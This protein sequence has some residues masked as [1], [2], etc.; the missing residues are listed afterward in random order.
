MKKVIVA[1]KNPVKIESARQAF[2]R[3][4][5]EQ[6]F[7]FEGVD[8]P[9]GVPDQPMGEE[10]TLLGA[11]NRAQNAR[12][13]NADFWVGIEGGVKDHEEQ[14]EAF[15]WMVVLTKDKKSIGRTG[16]FFLPHKVS[17]LVH[18]GIELGEADD[19]VFG[20]SDS[21]K[22][23]GSVGLLTH[24]VLDRA[25]Y[26]EQAIILALIPFMNEEFYF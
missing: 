15:A 3:V 20:Q 4:F 5:P 16:S 26:Y 25:T 18:Q 14:L 6:I 11:T 12:T 1:S 17:E 19:I 23:Q 21:K 9:S 24:G 22:K 8:V 7:D 13:F 2:C 10:E